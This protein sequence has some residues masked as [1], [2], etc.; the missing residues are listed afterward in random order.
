MVIITGNYNNPIISVHIPCATPFFI[1][2]S[3]CHCCYMITSKKLVITILIGKLKNE[4][5]SNY[6]I[7]TERYILSVPHKKYFR[8]LRIQGRCGLMGIGNLVKS[9]ACNALKM[10]DPNKMSFRGQSMVSVSL[11]YRDAS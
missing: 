1:N 8:W 7:L 4:T 11:G 9:N 2:G 10:M 3:Y 5:I 6:H